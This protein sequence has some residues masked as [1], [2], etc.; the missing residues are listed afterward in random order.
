MPNYIDFIG[1]AA[2]AFVLLSFFM[3]KIAT[4]RMVSIVGC[5]L[6]IAYG[7]LI[8]SKPI[9]ITNVSIVLVNVYYLMQYYRKGGSKG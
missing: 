4:L 1:Y 7:I 6:F 3:K 5:G 8:A 2:S 9:I